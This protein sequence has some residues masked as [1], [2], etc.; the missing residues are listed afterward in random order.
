MIF[1]ISIFLAGVFAAGDVVCAS[2]PKDKYWF[3]MR[4]WTQARQMG[5]QA[6]RAMAD[7]ETASMFDFSFE[8]FAHITRFF[9]YKVSR[10]VVNY[11][12]VY[13]IVIISVK[14]QIG[15]V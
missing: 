13:C 6:A 3:Q 11:L 12:Y 5:N 8:M 4:L 2:W 1:N 10:G 15:T 7:P 14:A 9:G